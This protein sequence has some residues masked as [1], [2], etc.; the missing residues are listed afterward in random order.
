MP[1]D[2]LKYFP[3]DRLDKLVEWYGTAL[4]FFLLAAVVLLGTGR[5]ELFSPKVSITSWS[6][7][8]TT[9]FFWL[10]WKLLIA[11]RERR[12]QTDRLKE[13]I[14]LSLFLFFVL[15]AI[16]LLPDFRAAG[17]FRYLFFGCVHALMVIDLFKDD[18]RAHLLF[19]L[20]GLL[21]GLL[22]IRGIL[23]NPSVLS[24]DPMSRL[25]FPLDHANTTGYLFVMSLPLA[26]GLIITQKGTLRALA[27]ASFAA[28]LAGLVLTYSRGAWLA[29]IA[30]MVFLLVI[31]RRWKL[32]LCLLLVP[33]VLYTF[34]KPLRERALTLM[35]P[36]TDVALNDRMRVMKGALE[37][38]YEN[39]ILGIGY[40]R[41]RLKESLKQTYEGTADETSPIWHA[42]NVYIELFAESGILG[43]GAFL[44]LMAQV[45]SRVMRRAHSA[46]DEKAM[47]LFALGA[48][49]V[50]F[51][52]A[53]LGDVPFYHHEPRIFFFTLLGLS[54]LVD[55]PAV[56]IHRR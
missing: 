19:L 55:A 33:A 15:V 56:S 28:Q 47:I 24:L 3:A 46:K 41:G 23:G 9:F 43:M 13:P 10:G 44:W 54:S 7:S 6:I 27:M 14:P 39:P 21:P 37:L 18:R 26:L 30:S 22:T 4:F 29:W 17:D 8:R 2:S 32:I 1:A 38:G 40:G 36:Q 53:G 42:H 34:V 45:F 25:G 11:M 12:L 48:A 16:S 20:L 50:A 5:I 52:V 31:S 49:W 35:T 51:A